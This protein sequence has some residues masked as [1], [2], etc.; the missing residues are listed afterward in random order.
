MSLMLEADA[1]VAHARSA[2]AESCPAGASC[3]LLTLKLRP[4]DL[5][6]VTLAAQRVM[7]NADAD[8]AQAL[9]VTEDE[10]D[11]EALWLPAPRPASKLLNAGG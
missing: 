11:A 3:M 7:P 8:D 5:T 10:E 4:Q 6:I 1:V 2:A 9:D